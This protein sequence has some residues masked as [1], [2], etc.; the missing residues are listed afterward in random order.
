MSDWSDIAFRS[1]AELDHHRLKREQD[2]LD[3]FFIITARRR[4]AIGSPLRRWLH[5]ER[6]AENAKAWAEKGMLPD[7]R[8]RDW[9]KPMHVGSRLTVA[10]I[11]TVN[12]TVPPTD[13][14]IPYKFKRPDEP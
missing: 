5:A 1:Q 7:G 13:R 12:V 11:A 9:N 3:A 4:A 10:E 8:S 2:M 14:R 6:A